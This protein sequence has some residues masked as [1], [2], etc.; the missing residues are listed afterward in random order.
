[1]AKLI[2]GRVLNTSPRIVETKPGHL[3][4]SCEYCGGPIVRTSAK[5][6]MD[7]A[8]RCSEKRFKAYIKKNPTDPVIKFL[9]KYGL[10]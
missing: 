10:A 3:W 1:M 5:Y 4:V 8:K 7:C 6:G 9:R 2:R